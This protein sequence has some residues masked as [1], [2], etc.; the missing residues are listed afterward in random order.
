MIRRSGLDSSPS[1]TVD[2]TGRP[3]LDEIAHEGSDVEEA[4]LTAPVRPDEDLKSV[5]RL[6]DVPQRSKPQR[7]NS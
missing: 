2:C 1:V 3:R 7:L 6:V 4:G 5:D